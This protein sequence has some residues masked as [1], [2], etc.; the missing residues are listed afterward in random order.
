MAVQRILL[1]IAVVAA[2]ALVFGLPRVFEETDEAAV[3]PVQLQERTHRP[4]R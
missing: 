3:P 1:L 2:V 4:P